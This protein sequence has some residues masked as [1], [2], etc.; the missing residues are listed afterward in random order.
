MK[1]KVLILC[2]S[3][4]DRDPRVHREIVFLKDK[5]DLTVAGLSRPLINEGYDFIK[6]DY[7]RPLW[8]IIIGTINLLLRRY[9]AFYWSGLYIKDTLKKLM[10]KD[11]D[12]ILANDLNTLPVS[13]KLAQ[14]KKTKVYIDAHEYEPMHYDDELWFRILMQDYWNYICKKYLPQADFMTTVSKGISQEYKRVF[15]VKS[16]IVTNAPFYCQTQ[17]S[18]TGDKISLIHHGALS[19]SRKHESLIVL[20]EMLD[21]RFTLDFMMIPNDKK[22]LEELKHKAKNNPRISF[23]E[24]VPMNKIC[25]TIC[26]YDI[27]IYMLESNSFNTRMSLPNK[28]FEFVQSRL[29]IFIWPSQEM[30]EYVESYKLGK[31]TEKCSIPE[32]ADILNNLTKEE[33]DVYK[34]NADSTAHLINAEENGKLICTFVEKL[35]KD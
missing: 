7:P 17:P 5:Y 30:A 16:E 18:K 33:I 27:G 24:P 32:M 9:E 19:R 10:N 28:F 22:Y 8:W 25:E 35:L 23:K 3:N 20:M 29:A 12:L 34:K 14:N 31:V 11:F 2:Y 4:L 21:E 1:K 15:G 13:L 6:I 26:N